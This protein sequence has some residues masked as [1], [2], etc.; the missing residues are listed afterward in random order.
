MHG[1]RARDHYMRV[2]WMAIS[3]VTIPCVAHDKLHETCMFHTM[4]KRGSRKHLT[5]LFKVL[6]WCNACKN[7]VITERYHTLIGAYATNLE[8]S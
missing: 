5:G 7:E 3:C 2:A 8:Y 4:R 1:L 6:S